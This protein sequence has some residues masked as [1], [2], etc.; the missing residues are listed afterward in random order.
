MKEISYKVNEIF[1]SVQGEGIFVG[2]P[3]NFIRFTRCNLSC[4]WCDTAYGI[5][6]E[7]SCA[8]I[9][10]KLDK[11]IKWVSLTGGEPLMEKDLP[12][13]ISKLKGN[14]FSVLLETNGSMYD[15]KI[16]SSCDHVSLDLKAPSSGNCLNNADALQYCLRHPKKSQVKVVVQDAV[17]LRFFAKMHSYGAGYPNWIIQ[18]EWSRIGEIDYSKIIRKFPGVRVIPQMHKLLKV[19]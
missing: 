18:P 3:M 8:S 15:K 16:F 2:L 9:I 11:K 1:A 17:D 6:D 7:L 5:G 10:K 13:I 12:Y 4:K 14:G 19:R